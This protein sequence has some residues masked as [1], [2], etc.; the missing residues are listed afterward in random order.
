MEIALEFITDL[1]GEIVG[2]Q[3]GLDIYMIENMIDFRKI[4]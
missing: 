4:N 1:N 3:A 2:L